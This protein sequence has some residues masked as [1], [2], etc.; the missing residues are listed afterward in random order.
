MRY[1][2]QSDYDKALGYAKA[3]NALHH[4]ALALA[5]MVLCRCQDYPNQCWSLDGDT[6]ALLSRD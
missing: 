4:Y 3:C 5:G 1:M 6:L 2:R